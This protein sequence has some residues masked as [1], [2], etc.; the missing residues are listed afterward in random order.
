MISKLLSITYQLVIGL[1]NS[2]KLFPYKRV[3]IYNYIYNYSINIDLIWYI[4]V[5]IH[6]NISFLLSQLLKLNNNRNFKYITTS[7][8]VLY[9][10]QT[11]KN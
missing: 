11:T 9:Y 7:K 5:N 2:N 4:A 3:A 1:I 8:K 10:L 6:L